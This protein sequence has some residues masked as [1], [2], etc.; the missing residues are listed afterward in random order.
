MFNFF[1]E[2][3]VIFYMVLILFVNFALRFYSKQLSLGFMFL[4]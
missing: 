3:V 2:F 4:I 1:C